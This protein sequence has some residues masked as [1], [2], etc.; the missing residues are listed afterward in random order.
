MKAFWTWGLLP[1]TFRVASCLV[2]V[3]CLSSLSASEVVKY[4]SSLELA[5]CHMLGCFG[6][7]CGSIVGVL[8]IE[9]VRV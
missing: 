7:L 4:D 2:G 6:L 1:E 8:P 5:T 9:S 3:E